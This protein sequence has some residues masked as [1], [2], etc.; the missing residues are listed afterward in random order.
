LS[1]LE[2]AEDGSGGEEKEQGSPEKGRGWS[3]LSGLS[4]GIKLQK[5]GK[6]LKNFEITVFGI[7]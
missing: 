7:L 2:G 3:G 5:T 1:G 6:S 4:H